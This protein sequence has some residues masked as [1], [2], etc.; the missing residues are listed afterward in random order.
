MALALCI[1][2]VLAAESASF[3]SSGMIIG[4]SV[5]FYQEAHTWLE[6]AVL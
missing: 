5:F 2:C 3:H 1:S 4:G 6:F